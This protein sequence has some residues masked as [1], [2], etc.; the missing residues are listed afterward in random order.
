MN[1]KRLGSA[2]ALAA[3][4]GMTAAAPAV[5]FVFD[6]TLE[7]MTLSAAAVAMPLG[8]SA[9]EAN[10]YQSVLSD[11]VLTLSSQRVSNPGP[12]TLGQTTAIEQGSSF[13]VTSFF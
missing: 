5:A 8:R 9:T 3:A 13:N 12:R 6:T 11:V 10:G 7:S 2:L 1:E 4:F